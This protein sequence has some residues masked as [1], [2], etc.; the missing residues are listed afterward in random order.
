MRTLRL[1][2]SASLILLCAPAVAA[3]LP[4]RPVYKAPAAVPA[5][6]WHGWYVG[7]GGGYGWG[8]PVAHVD[9]AL[10]PPFDFGP[11]ID[12]TSI[13][14]G[15]PF[16]L[17]TRPHGWLAG[18]LVGRNWQLRNGHVAG[19]EADLYWADLKD[20]NTG[21]F[22][23]LV[24]YDTGPGGTTGTVSIESKL[25]WFATFR[26]RWGRAMG[27]AL[28]YITAGL[29]VGGVKSHVASSGTHF[30]SQGNT[31]SY[32]A[33]GSFS[34]VLWGVAAGGGLDWAIDERWRLRGEYLYLHLFGGDHSPTGLP[35]VT[36]VS[37]EMDAHIARAAIIRR[38]VPR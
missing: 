3:D 23:N 2:A 24:V 20:S 15:A 12:P 11:S 16:S 8:D 28:P 27:N 5:P 30:A 25:N 38:F 17:R 22:T 37:N 4:A 18:G 31:A 21:S 13:A 32:A 6:L 10:I 36:K 29:A 9:P 33:A 19:F 1:I 26:G 35:G 7:I 14:P 34:D